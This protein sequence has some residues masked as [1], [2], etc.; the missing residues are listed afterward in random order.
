MQLILLCVVLHAGIYAQEPLS[1]PVEKKQP[2][3]LLFASLPQQFEVSSAEL[4][5]IL[6]GN[7]NEKISAQLSS[8]F[9]VVGLVVDKNQ[10]T[11]GTLTLNIRLENYRNALFNLTIRLLADNSTGIQGRVIHPRYGDVLELY[12][13]K[14]R[15][16]IKKV[17]QRLFMPD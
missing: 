5:R 8:Q 7:L 13:E 3:P 10:H 15:Y 11:P 2:K 17:S 12:K 16:Y 9:E 1:V 4:H 6:A 14:D